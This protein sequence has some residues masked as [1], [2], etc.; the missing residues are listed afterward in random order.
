MRT[1]TEYF[2]ICSGF[3]LFSR[4]G[5]PWI[6]LAD[7]L[8]LLFDVPGTDCELHIENI[9]SVALTGS[10]RLR[11]RDQGSRGPKKR[12]PRPRLRLSGETLNRTEPRR[13]RSR[14]RHTRSHHGRHGQWLQDGVVTGCHRRL[15]PTPTHSLTYP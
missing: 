13:D 4:A 15:R 5:M 11:V 8:P 12:G 10:K 2:T 7:G 14:R 3:S 9:R 6:T 1:R